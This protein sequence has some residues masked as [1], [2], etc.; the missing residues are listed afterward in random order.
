MVVLLEKDPWECSWCG[1][2]VGSILDPLRDVLLPNGS[3]KGLSPLQARADPAGQD[4]RDTLQPLLG[5]CMAAPC[6]LPWAW[7]KPLQVF[8]LLRGCFPN[9]VGF[10]VAKSITKP[11][12]PFPALILLLPL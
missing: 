3:A 11:L 8:N 2:A 12:F 5:P 7:L 6:A 10:A 1:A 9:R 4:S